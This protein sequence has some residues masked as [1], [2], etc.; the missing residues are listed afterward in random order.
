MP[1]DGSP[2]VCRVTVRAFGE[3]EREEVGFIVAHFET[4]GMVARRAAAALGLHPDGRYTLRY[5]EVVTL[6]YDGRVAWEA[7]SDGCVLEVVD[8]GGG[9]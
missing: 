7:I 8:L 1:R 2:H 5:D 3:P 9:V 4:N 6:D